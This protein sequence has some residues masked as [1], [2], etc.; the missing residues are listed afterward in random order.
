MDFLP[1]VI[2]KTAPK[3][4]S[5]PLADVQKFPM[6]LGRYHRLSMVRCG[7]HRLPMVP[8]VFPQQPVVLSSFQSLSVVLSWWFL[9]LTLTTLLHLTLTISLQIVPLLLLLTYS[10]LL[11]LLQQLESNESCTLVMRVQ[12]V[13]QLATQFGHYI[14][15]LQS[16]VEDGIT[17]GKSS[18][19]KSG[20]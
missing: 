2:I 9:N 10:L 17:N 15:M 6:V 18:V 11:I 8:D 19:T 20:E 7:F 5:V 4:C 13:S 3:L 14:T 16:L 12:T 1:R